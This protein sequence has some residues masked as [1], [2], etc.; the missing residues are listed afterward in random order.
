[1]TCP[2]HHALTLLALRHSATLLE[3]SSS[4]LGLRCL[5]AIVRATGML[6]AAQSWHQSGCFRSLSGANF[7]S[8]C[9]ERHRAPLIL[10][11]QDCWRYFLAGSRLSRCAWLAVQLLWLSV[12]KSVFSS[13]LRLVDVLLQF[14]FVLSPASVCDFS[15]KFDCITQHFKLIL[16]LVG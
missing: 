3:Y 1:M 4:V 16:C 6:V 10:S 9:W 7:F 13:P 14:E 2:P 8:F 11:S 15:R 5:A 12:M